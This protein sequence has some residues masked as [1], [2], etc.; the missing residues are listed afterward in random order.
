MS[1][2]N[3]K[4]AFI[5]KSNK[6]I[7]FNFDYKELKDKNIDIKNIN[8]NDILKDYDFILIYDKKL[9]KHKNE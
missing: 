6:D 9:T 1:C 7:R 4:I 5:N 2:N 3:K 8:K